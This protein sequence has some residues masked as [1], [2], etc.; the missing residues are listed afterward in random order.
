M[1][2]SPYAKALTLP[3]YKF[4]EERK[5]LCPFHQFSFNTNKYKKCNHSEEFLAHGFQKLS[6]PPPLLWLRKDVFSVGIKTTT[7]PG[8]LFFHLFLIV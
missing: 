8:K 1:K 3:K 2:V 6:D 4:K 5:T 7:C